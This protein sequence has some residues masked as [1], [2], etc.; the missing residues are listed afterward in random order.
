M[1]VRRSGKLVLREEAR[2]LTME[3]Q[4]VAEEVLKALKKIRAV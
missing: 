4:V 1:V 3:A 2:M